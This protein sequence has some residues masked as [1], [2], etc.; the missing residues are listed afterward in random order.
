MNNP[1]FPRSFLLLQ[2]EAFL[3]RTS[4]AQGLT[5]LGSANIGEKGK[6]YG[7]FFGL[8]IGIERLLK[9]ILILDHMATHGANPPERSAVRAY[10]HD[11]L[12]LIERA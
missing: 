10:G 7:A 2:Q 11:I 1:P 9:V 5:L 12:G 8:S 4:L 3:I 6:Y